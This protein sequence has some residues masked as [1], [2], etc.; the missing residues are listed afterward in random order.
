MLLADFE[1]EQAMS[2]EE[3]AVVPFQDRFLRPASVDLQ[4]GHEL[5]VYKESEDILLPWAVEEGATTLRTLARGEIYPLMPGQ[6]LLA[7]TLQYIALPA[8]MVACVEGQSDLGR[9]GM[10]INSTGAIYP[11]FRGQISLGISNSNVRPLALIPGMLIAQ[12]SFMPVAPTR[13]HGPV[14]LGSHH[15]DQVGVRD[16]A[17]QQLIE[18]KA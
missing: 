9:L 18:I 7:H 2:H 11:G 6:Y 10:R 8:T 17:S 12:I 15:Q 13:L 1:I 16:T 5:R 4:L 3:L 14:S